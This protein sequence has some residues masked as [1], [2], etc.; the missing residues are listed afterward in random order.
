[1]PNAEKSRSRPRRTAAACLLAFTIG[2]CPAGFAQTNGD[3]SASQSNAEDTPRAHL[4]AGYENLK[5]NRYDAAAREFRAALALDPKL[6]LQAR[7]SLA[8]S[9]FE[10]HQ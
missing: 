7:F 3:K 8:V 9:L 6:L 4:G 2:I 5:N 10:L 1:M